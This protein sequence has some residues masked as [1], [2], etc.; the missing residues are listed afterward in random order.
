MPY[1][2]RY[3]LGART[4]HVDVSE[5]LL[6]QQQKVVVVCPVSCVII[7]AEN[8]GAVGPEKPLVVDNDALNIGEVWASHGA[9]S[10]VGDAGTIEERGHD[11]VEVIVGKVK[12]EVLVVDDK[13]AEVG[14]NKPLRDRLGWRVD[15][16][17]VKTE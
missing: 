1:L 10:H 8:L 14:V 17:Q 4:V 2:T 16:R 9:L 6:K 13:R 7:L 3:R 5:V 12:L 15:N 11:C